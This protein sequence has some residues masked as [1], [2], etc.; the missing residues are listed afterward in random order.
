[1]NLGVTFRMNNWTTNKEI[2][3]FAFKKAYK[4]IT[5]LS[6]WPWLNIKIMRNSFLCV[7]KVRFLSEIIL[8]YV[9]LDNIVVYR[10]MLFILSCLHKSIWQAVY[11]GSHHHQ[12]SVKQYKPLFNRWF[13]FLIGTTVFIDTN[14]VFI[15]CKEFLPYDK[16][17]LQ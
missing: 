7:G 1:M 5:R 3:F 15:D 2:L 10:N 11:S 6:H 14:K 9:K 8:N 4:S 13:F 17:R 16:T 12:N